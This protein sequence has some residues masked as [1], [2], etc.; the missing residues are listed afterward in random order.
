MSENPPLWDL[1]KDGRARLSFDMKTTKAYE[2]LLVWRGH[3]CI[4]Y[5]WAARYAK[6][7]SLMSWVV[8]IPKE[9]LTIKKEIKKEKKDKQKIQNIFFFSKKKKKK[10]KKKI[11]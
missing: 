5:L 7:R 1:P 11:K 8:A 10:K 3:I 4:I 9:G 6:K 2:D